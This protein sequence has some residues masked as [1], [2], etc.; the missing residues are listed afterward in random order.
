MVIDT[1]RRYCKNENLICVHAAYVVVRIILSFN[2]IERHEP[3][4]AVLNNRSIA[5]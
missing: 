1:C 2:V 5:H 4:L 3:E